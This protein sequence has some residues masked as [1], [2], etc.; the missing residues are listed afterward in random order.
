VRA[1]HRSPLIFHSN[2]PFLG[3]GSGCVVALWR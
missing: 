1:A 2:L 3:V